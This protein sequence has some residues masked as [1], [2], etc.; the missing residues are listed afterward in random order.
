MEAATAHVG[1]VGS[2]GPVDVH[3]ER[4]ETGRGGANVL[5]VEQM[6]DL[7]LALGITQ[8]ELDPSLHHQVG[9]NV[10][11]Q[12]DNDGAAPRV[13]VQARQRFNKNEL[14]RFTRLGAQGGV[15]DV[16]LAG[17]LDI[18]ADGNLIFADGETQ[19]NPGLMF[20][21]EPGDEGWFA[22][23]TSARLLINPE[24]DGAMGTYADLFLDA[25][26]PIDLAVNVGMSII[27]EPDAAVEV[28]DLGLMGYARVS[29]YVRPNHTGGQKTSRRNRRTTFGPSPT[30]T[31]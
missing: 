31:P 26:T 21:W 2:W 25:I 1:A 30:T 9:G 27:S 29:Y 22:V 17:R 23:D 20:L 10:V 13:Q 7:G 4:L 14:N 5:G 28:P 19:L 8:D 3:A 6:L 11:L 16:A 24:Y 12:P 15:V 18:L